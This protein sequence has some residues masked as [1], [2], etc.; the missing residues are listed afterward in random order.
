MR[1]IKSVFNRISSAIP[2]TEGTIGIIG[3]LITTLLI[4]ADVVNRYWL[5]FEIMGISDLALYCFIFFMWIAAAF[6]TWRE[7]HVSVDFLRE[8]ITKRKL[9]LAAAYSFFLVF[10]SLAALFLLFP[11]AYKFMLT[12]IKYPE[13][14]T[15]IRWFNQSWLQITFFVALVLV[16]AHLLSIAWREAGK[17][18]KDVTDR[19]HKGKT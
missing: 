3:V 2:V 8:R 1:R 12:A 6:T 19:A 14:G 13:F 11:E 16:A 18:I 15:L 17:L 5:H 9:I 4:F 7:G 10:L